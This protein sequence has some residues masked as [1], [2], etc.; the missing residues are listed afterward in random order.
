[1]KRIYLKIIL[2]LS[3]IFSSA[4]IYADD[5]TDDAAEVDYYVPGILANDAMQQVNFLLC[6]MQ[7]TNGPTF[8]DKGAYAALV[9][10]AKCETASG[11]DAAS[12]GAAATGGSSAGGGGGVAGAENAVEEV[13]YTSGIYQNVT[14]GNTAAGKGWVDL[15]LDV[16]APQDIPV[17][18]YVSSVI[19]ADK[20]AT[21]KFGT[22]TMRY[23]LRN[24]Q[25]V[26]GVFPTANMQLNQGYLKVDGSTIEYFENDLRMPPRSIKVDLADSNNQQGYLQTV[27]RT[28][29]GETQRMFSVKHKVSVNEG[30]NQYCQKFDGAQ[31][32]QAGASGPQPLGSAIAEG[33]FQTI[34]TSV[35][36]GGGYV[37]TD[38]GTAA[39]ITGEHCWDT[40]R[41]EAKRVVYQYGTY[42]N[43][44]GSRAN[45][46]NPSMSLEANGTDNPALGTNRIYSHASYWGV[47]LDKAFRS[48]VTDSTIFRNQ[49]SS[50]DDKS[51]SLR[52]NY[53]EIEKNTRQ[54]LSLNQLG[55]VSF[56]FHVDGF[57]NNTTFRPKVNALGFPISGACNAST[58]N[59]PEYS[60]T[61]TVSGSTVTFKATHGMDWGQNIMPFKL[62]NEITFTAADWTTQMI[63][64]SYGRRMHFWDPDSHQSYTIPYAAFGTI[65]SSTPASQVRTRIR[66]KIDIDQLALELGVDPLLCIRECLGAAEMN[67]A[68][69]AA[70]SA[71]AAE[72]TPGVLNTSPYEPIG[73]YFPVTAYYDTN[74]SETQD[75]DEPDI[76]IGR[77]NN[78]GGV[79]ENAAMAYT[80]NSGKLREG[81]SGSTFLEYSNSN[82]ALVDARQHGDSLSNYSY[83]VKPDNT[84]ADNWYQRFGY[85]FHM[86][87]F[88]GSTAN[89]NA[90]K[91]DAS[92]GNARGYDVRFRAKSTGGGWY[93]NSSLLVTGTNY[94]C[95]YKI[96]EGAIDTTYEIRIKQ[97][98]DYRLYSNTDSAF[99]D[100]SAPQKVLFTVPAASEITY[101]FDDDLEGQK[102]KLKFEGYG[103]LHNLPG[104][105]VNTCTGA[106]LGR[107]VSGWN[108]CYRYV[109]EFIIPDGTVL[110]NLSGGDDL[111]VRAL[112]GD[113]FL[114]KYSSIPAG[115]TYT[116]TSADLPAESNLQ[117][118]YDG[119]D[120]I[121]D[122]PSTI[123]N[124]GEPSVIHGETVVAPQ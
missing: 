25:A 12:E 61:I 38:G 34:L 3:T 114:K 55:G 64:S 63:D 39:T 31:E 83:Y 43:S 16:G 97:M 105:V 52:K 100:V 54:Y 108:P 107:Y 36:G 117:N 28:V 70:F 111:K 7:K 6:F 78:I 53:L 68:I 40:R 85:S 99:V 79:T 113:E 18:A 29:Q 74:G 92:G 106:I 48:T 4:F 94:L 45:L 56:Q 93:A 101:N 76:Q 62:D 27:V 96:W 17:K 88:K 13:N 124:N 15:F 42:K 22:F 91:C 35:T 95:D 82:A 87:A 72:D 80:V 110:T 11:A 47:H 41:S 71:V 26:S 115:V 73:P 9:D 50:S 98:P 112:R 19:S 67:A 5:Y 30:A 120:A 104:R 46:T 103:E 118:L 119:A 49:R 44:D 51:Y 60:G 86:R 24:K 109:H 20:S 8:L 122:V 57:K 123:L 121:G 84:Y 81:T 10:E 2:S 116:A 23:D 37:D 66:T 75:G 65:D 90:L 69:T 1:M 21:N 59:C 14:Q 33:N 89:K 32:Y 77:Y 58:G 102:F